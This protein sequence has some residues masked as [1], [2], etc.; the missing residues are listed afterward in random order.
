MGKTIL[1][2][3]M[4]LDGFTAG[5]AISKE[6]PLG[7]NGVLLHKWIFED[8][9]ETDADFFSEFLSSVGSVIVGNRTYVTAIEE[10]W[11]AR[12]P[13]DAP[14]FVLCHKVPEFIVDGF[15]FIHDGIESALTKA[16][17]VA[18]DKN[19]WVMG[20][21]NIIQQYLCAGLAD[22]LQLHIAPVLLGA[23]TLL[24]N[25]CNENPVELIKTKLIDSKSVTHIFYKLKPTAAAS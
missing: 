8:K 14:A 1:D 12:S 23:G 6:N 19:V 20:G 2:I 16:K 22:E 5:P 4:S 13:F 9:T 18:G 7:I 3:T 15:S 25:A 21:A 17:A 11:G 24:F 10:A